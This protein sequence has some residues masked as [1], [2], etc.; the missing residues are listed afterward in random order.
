MKSA[1]QLYRESG[2]QIPFKEWVNNQAKEGVLRD[3]T[4]PNDKKMNADGVGFELFGIDVKYI[5]IAG[6]VIAGAFYAYKKF[7]K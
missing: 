2:S 7:K 4:Q 5:L 3:Y 1:N 6:V